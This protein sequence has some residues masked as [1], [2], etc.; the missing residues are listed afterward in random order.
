MG[1]F[2]LMAVICAWLAVQ[3]RDRWLGVNAVLFVGLA[4]MPFL[5]GAVLLAWWALMALMAWRV[6][7]QN[8]PQVWRGRAPQPQSDRCVVCIPYRNSA[9]S[10]GRE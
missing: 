6:V 8:H 2:L 9:A 5:G 10:E 3:L 4:F 7:G 1:F